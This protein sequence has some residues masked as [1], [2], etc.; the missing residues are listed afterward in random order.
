MNEPNFIEKFGLLTLAAIATVGLLCIAWFSLD[1]GTVDASMSALLGMIVTGLIALAK[2]IIQAIRGYQMNAQLGKVTDQLARS[3]PQV[4]DP[5][6]P[7][8][9][10][11]TNPQEDPVHVEVT[12]P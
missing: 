11:V 8:E 7:Q 3:A 12:R 1:N 10:V 2:D 9:V 5:T 6:V 4:T